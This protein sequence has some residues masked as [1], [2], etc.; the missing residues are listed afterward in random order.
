MK[1][2]K[3]FDLAN[4]VLDIVSQRQPS[5]FVP[6]KGKFPLLPQCLAEDYSKEVASSK[7]FK[8]TPVWVQDIINQALKIKRIED[9]FIEYLK[10]NGIFKEFKDMDNSDKATE[11]ARFLDANCMSLE[12]LQIN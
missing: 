4:E 10:F 12:Y 1:E 9:G 7:L 6:F 11:L 3:V 8:E 5:S 2:V